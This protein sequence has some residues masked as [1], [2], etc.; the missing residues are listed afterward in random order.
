MRAVIYVRTSGLAQV[1]REG[2][3][4][5]EDDCRA[6]AARLG[7]EVVAVFH[8]RAT[9]GGVDERPAFADALLAV[10]DG[11][12][13]V[14][15]LAHIDRLA[16]EL[17]VQEGLLASAWAAGAEVHS[18]SYGLIPR[19]DPSDPMRTF[20]RQVMGAVAQLDRAIIT[21]RMMKARTLIR[22]QGGKAEGR[23]PFGWSKSGPVE[24]EQHVLAY[25]RALVEGGH[26]LA[27]VASRLNSRSAEWHQRN[28]KPWTRQ[29][30]HVVCRNAG[31][32]GAREPVSDAAASTP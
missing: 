10:E 20:I 5:Q 12:A 6:Y 8:E 28:G 16:R 1:E 2:P 31:I 26:S 4:V 23:Y 24:R 27:V 15:L 7:M 25:A 9:P 32:T 14:V 22:E 11:E 18:A 29:N 19:D 30:L 13:E 21:A 3:R 17:T